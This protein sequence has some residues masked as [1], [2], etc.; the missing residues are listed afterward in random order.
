MSA[1]ERRTVQ[2]LDRLLARSRLATD[3]VHGRVG[4]GVETRAGNYKVAKTLFECGIRNVPAH[5]AL[6]QAHGALHRVGYILYII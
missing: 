4:G 5:G 2:L 6:W 1:R 3:R